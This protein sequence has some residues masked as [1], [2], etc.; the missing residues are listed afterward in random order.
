MHITDIMPLKWELNAEGQS[1]ADVFFGRYHVQRNPTDRWCWGLSF[2]GEF[3][4][5]LYQTGNFEAAK[6]SCQADYERRILSALV[7]ADALKEL[8][9]GD[10]R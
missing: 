2:Y 5:G 4:V 3:G 10:R 1:F 9:K 6:A 7:P 8:G